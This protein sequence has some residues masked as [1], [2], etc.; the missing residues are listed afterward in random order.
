MKKLRPQITQQVDVR[1]ETGKVCLDSRGYLNF[2]SLPCCKVY[3]LLMALFNLHLSGSLGY[4]L[5]SPNAKNLLLLLMGIVSFLGSGSSGS[6]APAEESW[7]DQPFLGSE[8]FRTNLR[9]D[10]SIPLAFSL[11]AGCLPWRCTQCPRFSR[12]G[13]VWT[14]LT[15][16]GVP[17]CLAERLLLA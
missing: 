14:Y 10:L 3:H 8:G 6:A 2:S 1:A 4:S 17:A 13:L 11:D 7:A 5:L 9:A 15:S 12:K 16:E